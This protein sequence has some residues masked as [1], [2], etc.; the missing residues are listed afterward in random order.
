VDVPKLP[1]LNVT[2]ITVNYDAPSLGGIAIAPEFGLGVHRECNNLSAV[3]E[4]DNGVDVGSP[5]NV[6]FEIDGDRIKCSPVRVPGL[7]GGANKTVYC[8]C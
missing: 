4:E 3:I 7:T 1:D 6:T 2:E 5:F 8:N